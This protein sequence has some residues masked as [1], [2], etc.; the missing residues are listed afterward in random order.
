MNMQYSVQEFERMQN[1][2]I[3]TIDPATVPDLEDIEIDESL[4]VE[5]RVLQ[6]LRQMNG[7]PFF[8]RCGGL[9]VKATY[10][11]TLPLQTVLEDCLEHAE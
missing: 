3:R 10:A 2:D 11:G 6:V 9:L 7:N 4:P 5:E 8:Y 1:M